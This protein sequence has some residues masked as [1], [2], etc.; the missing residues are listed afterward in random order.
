MLGRELKYEHGE[1]ASKNLAIVD[2]KLAKKQAI[3][4]CDYK[5]DL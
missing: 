5:I 1:K 3:G 4:A 2:E